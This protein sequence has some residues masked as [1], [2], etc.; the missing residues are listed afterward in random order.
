[1]AVAAC[2]AA[3]QVGEPPAQPTRPPAAI[4]P[5][6]TTPSPVGPQAC[7]S[8]PP[9][10]AYAQAIGT[11]GRQ[12]WRTELP[13]GD[14]SGQATKPPLLVDG[15]LIVGQSGVRAL[16]EASGRA[17]WSW[18]GGKT[19]YDMWLAHGRV[20]VL[21][22]QV[23][24]SAAL[25]ALDAATGHEV[26]RVAI[27]TGGLLGTVVRTASDRL[28]WVRAD[29]AVQVV[30]LA[31]GKLLWSHPGARSPAVAAIGGKVVFSSAGTTTAWD[32]ATGTQVWSV[33]GA[34][35]DAAVN[36]VG[37]RLMVWSRASGGTSPTAL[38][39]LDPATGA[40]VW[41]HDSGT[42]PYAV[43]DLAGRVLTFDLSA[44]LSALDA[45]SGR[46]EWNV[47]APRDAIDTPPVLLTD[48]FIEAEGGNGRGQARLVARSPETGAVL[49]STPLTDQIYGAQPLVS[50]GSLVVA[51]TPAIGYGNPSGLAAYSTVTGRPAWTAPVATDAQA[52]TA[53]DGDTLFVSSADPVMGCA[54]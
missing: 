4:T 31:D 51:Q 50:T 2:G 37:G 6:P 16:D 11:D 10:H 40:T 28:A 32:E 9:R 34:P 1:M 7:G 21:S 38:T 47:S 20:V 13:I 15:R 8:F 22:D 41:T 30:D 53:V 14:D 29:G 3:T 54:A 5:R 48:R 12:L 17:E 49:W 35:P 27:P 46:V 39:A 45:G 43:S 26:W 19:I 44:Q 23:G 33:P 18:T 36:P 42:T 24:P 25:T 52:P